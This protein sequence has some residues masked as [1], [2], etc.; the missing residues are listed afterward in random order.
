MLNRHYCFSVSDIFVTVVDFIRSFIIESCVEF[1][2]SVNF[3]V[4]VPDYPILSIIWP[5]GHLIEFLFTFSRD[6]SYLLF[7]IMFSTKIQAEQN[8]FYLVVNKLCF[9]TAI[10]PDPGFSKG[11]LSSHYYTKI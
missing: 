10:K 5:T 11:S 4:G 9:F 2:F 6:T 7:T 8:N 3:F 1:I